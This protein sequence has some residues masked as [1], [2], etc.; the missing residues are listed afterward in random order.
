MA[1]NL[2]LFAAVV[3][4]CVINGCTND[5]R[6]TSDAVEK[7]ELKIGLLQVEVGTVKNAVRRLNRI[8]ADWEFVTPNAPL[9][10]LRR[11]DVLWMPAEWGSSFG[12]SDLKPR[13]DAYVQAG[14]GIVYFE[15]DV[16][17]ESKNHAALHLLPYHV[18]IVR[19]DRSGSV[20]V[21][22]RSEVPNPATTGAMKRD[23][24][25]A[26]D[27]FVEFDE[28]WTPLAWSLDK[29]AEQHQ[30]IP[31]MLC[32]QVGGGRIVLLA[33]EDDELHQNHLSDRFVTKTLKWL[34]GLPDAEVRRNTARLGPRKY[35]PVVQQLHDDCKALLAKE[36]PDVQADLK[37]VEG[38]MS[39]T[40]KLNSTWGHQYESLEL[41]TKH[42]SLATVA[43]GLKLLADES[44]NDWHFREEFCQIFRLH[45][46][47][48]VTYDDRHTLVRKWWPENR[49]SLTVDMNLMTDRQ[50]EVVFAELPTVIKEIESYGYERVAPIKPEIML[51]MMNGGTDVYRKGCPTLIDRNLIPLILDACRD[52]NQRWMMIGPLAAMFRFHQSPDLHQMTG[53]ETLDDGLRVVAIAA[54]HRAGERPDFDLLTKRYNAATESDIRQVLLVAMAAHEKLPG[55]SDTVV[56][57]LHDSSNEVAA[58]AQMMIRQSKGD[59]YVIPLVTQIKDRI[60]TGSRAMVEFSLLKNLVQQRPANRRALAELVGFVLSNQPEGESLKEA[61]DIFA[62]ATGQ[63]FGNDSDLPQERAVIALKWHNQQSQ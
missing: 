38:L 40:I 26:H 23:L 44:V 2:R 12:L 13:F 18:K 53:D 8:G 21:A 36:S 58:T 7:T 20:S 9:E 30:K 33:D 17:G 43:V 34:G 42:R 10:D 39:G 32:A 1:L 25:Q 63:R 22:Y 47:H 51:S 15:P 27:Q 61:V 14:G 45:T 4:V 35:D 24:P 62:R 16:D 31:T 48:A 55:A 54:L 28:G 56:A 19:R 41:M 37:R 59:R 57:A 6:S 49:D 5:E 50:L 11:F 3:A 29:N 60:A 52:K 46:G